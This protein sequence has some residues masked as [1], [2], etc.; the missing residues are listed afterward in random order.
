MF[1]QL[2]ILILPFIAFRFG[3]KQ[4][5][6]ESEYF[7]S[8]AGLFGQVAVLV[9]NADVGDD[10]DTKCLLQTLQHVARQNTVPSSCY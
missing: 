2:I 8:A 7:E 6:T 4:T 1:C 3:E 5:K 9:K 10:E